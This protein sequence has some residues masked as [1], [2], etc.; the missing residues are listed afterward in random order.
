M[1]IS[2]NYFLPTN[3]YGTLRITDLSFAG[4]TAVNANIYCQRNINC[5][6]QLQCG[7]FHSLGTSYFDQVPTCITNATTATQLT[8]L[9]T[10]QNL[11][12]AGGYITLSQAIDGVHVSILPF[13]AIQTINNNL[14]ITN[15]TITTSKTTI[16]QNSTTGQCIFTNQGNTAGAFLFIGY[17]G[18]TA[19]NLLSITSLLCSITSTQINLNAINA[20]SLV[21]ITTATFNG[22]YPTTT[23]GNNG[24]LNNNEFATV[25]YVKSIGGT[26]I[27]SLNNTW[28]GTN[29]F[30]VPIV[31]S[32][33][34]ITTGT[35]PA[36]SIVNNSLTNT[37]MATG[38]LLVTT[39]SQTF[40]GVKTLSSLLN[41]TGITDTV[42]ISSPLISGG[43]FQATGTS[44][45]TLNNTSITGTLYTNNINT[46]ASTSLNINIGSTSIPAG[47]SANSG[48]LVGWNNSAGNGET[49]F[50]NYAQGGTTANPS[51]GG[52]QFGSISNNLAY[53]ALC[54]M[55]PYSNQG[56]WLFS[57]CGR[58]RIDDRNGGAFWWSQSQEGSQMLCS[59]NGIST[60]YTVGCANSSG[61]GS[62]CLTVN[63]TAVTIAP[64]LNTS[65]TITSTGVI[66]A[67][68]YTATN[69]GGTSNFWGIQ[70]GNANI[71]GTLTTA[72]ITAQ[73]LTTF[74]TNHPTTNLGNNISTNTTQYATVG[75]VN[76][77]S[78]T[79]LLS[80][81]NIWTGTNA[82]TQRYISVGNQTAPVTIGNGNGNIANTNIG[83]PS[84][85]STISA[86]GGNI[87]VS[88][89]ISGSMYNA[90]G[91]SNICVGGSSASL[92]TT[93]NSN[94]FIGS[95]CG[96]TIT[97]AS[98][99]TILGAG[100]WST[101]TANF[102]NCTVLGAN[103]PPPVANNSIVIGSSAETLYVA[104]ASQL[105]NSLLFGTT[106]CSGD[107]LQINKQTKRFHTS[108]TLGVLNVINNPL[109]Y[110]ILFTPAAGMSFQFPPPSA[111]NSG[112]TFILRKDNAGV[113]SVTFSC[114]GTPAVW[115]PLNSGTANT[116][117]TIT[118][119]WQFTIYS[120]GTLYLTI[121]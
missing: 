111:T 91:S 54:A 14:V 108:Y 64:P 88:I 55:N 37:Q 9:Q 93:G 18:A 97:T 53:R 99:N 116:S 103:A 82:F 63:T 31:T 119:I 32:G 17:N 7:Q 85:L 51:G 34:S 110:M 10:V 26:S 86:T 101:G 4:Y 1:S 25:G 62:T 77:N 33:A 58:L 12:T 35:I 67:P 39:N 118:T 43:Y 113:G 102:S 117:L 27:L 41:T 76:A 68:S 45:T 38:F 114:S 56:F 92:L 84:S 100:A 65:S 112:Q 72:N 107:V 5:D 78:G 21:C 74:N 60:S 6:G 19:I 70:T 24:G 8:N 115:V 59:V 50:T 96:Q 13:T 66:S 80:S 98:N 28:T 83:D 120:T 90:T 16:S 48:L 104:G 2:Y 11:L 22:N 46:S 61:V 106:V 29:T 15:P 121:A 57:N 30:Q 52:F 42:S 20:N 95:G 109:P 44:T 75:F 23:L 73:G 94:T 105:N 79:S 49:D 69:S 71:S 87:C 81:N 89:P 40:S 36:L 3:I 47:T